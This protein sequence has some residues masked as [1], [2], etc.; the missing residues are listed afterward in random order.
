[1]TPT[2]TADRGQAARTIHLID[3]AGFDASDQMPVV[4]YEEFWTQG[5]SLVNGDI[6]AQEAADAV[7]AVWPAE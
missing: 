6:T 4:V 5:T 7:E 3:P 1:M 2:I